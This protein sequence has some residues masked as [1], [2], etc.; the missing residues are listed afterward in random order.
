MRKYIFLWV[1]VL[2]AALSACSPSEDETF[3]ELPSRRMQ[4]VVT[5]VDSILVSPTNGWLM[6]YYPSSTQSYG[7]YNVLAKF[8]TDGTVTMASETAGADV[9]ATSEYDVTQ[10]SG[11]VLTFDTYNNAFHAFSTPDESQGA[12]LGYGYQGDFEFVVMSATPDEIVLKGRKTGAYAVMKPITPAISWDAY[13]SAIKNES[14][15]IGNYYRLQYHLG[16][17]IY[18]ARMSNRHVT[19]YRMTGNRAWE[20]EQNIPFVVT[21]TGLHFYKPL[22]MDSVSID[23]LMFDPLKGDEG[24]WVATNNDRAIFYP[25]YPPLNELILTSTW[26]FTCKD[27]SEEARNW[28]LPAKEAMDTAGDRLLN[29][30]ITWTENIYTDDLTFFFRC[31]QHEYG[32]LTLDY[33][34]I[35]DSQ[36]SLQFGKEGSQVGSLHYKDMHFNSILSM[37]G[38]EKKRTFT[39]RADNPKNPQE[40]TFTDNSDSDNWF[41]L[42]RSPVYYPF[43]Y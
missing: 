12:G 25:S 38:N 24:A 1:A 13:L 8:S 43:N 15:F 7:G 40:I 9:T 26:Y 11:C 29:A 37:L 21:M 20:V 28:W 36:I 31:S 18:E 39:L 5:H 3:G 4:K 14:D 16:D 41:T 23:G 35:G 42:H 19:V 17:S 22:Q 6:Q 2:L 34:L 33:D 27:M 10:S 32:Y 30:S